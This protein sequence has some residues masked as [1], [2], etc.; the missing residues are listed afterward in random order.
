MM[1]NLNCLKNSLLEI[2]LN[3]YPINLT[4][5][6]S[7]LTNL[8]N[9]TT[10]EKD[11][12]NLDL[13]LDAIAALELYN[14]FDYQ[15]AYRKLIK[16]NWHRMHENLVDSLDKTTFNEDCFIHVLNQTYDYYAD[17]VEDFM[18]P[19]WSKCLWSLY[20]IGSQ[21]GSDVIQQFSNSEYDYL[22]NTA[23]ALLFKINN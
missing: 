5:E 18:V 11:G 16:E 17:G 1:K 14:D 10:K 13:L 7:Y 22:K 2:F 3:S 12:E 8:I 19:I 9:A 15:S 4:Q 6:K 23:N 20:R 21:K